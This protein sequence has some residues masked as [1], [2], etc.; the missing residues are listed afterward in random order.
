MSLI[1]EVGLETSYTILIAF[2]RRCEGVKADPARN[3]IDSDT[4][5]IV[6]EAA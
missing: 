3:T 2:P 6:Q 4:P 5:M 1:V